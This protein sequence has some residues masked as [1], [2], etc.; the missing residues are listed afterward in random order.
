MADAENMATMER[1]PSTAAGVAGV[2]PDG[3]YG[4]ESVT[5][6]SCKWLY[7][8]ITLD[9]SGRIFPCCAAPRPDMDLVFSQFEPGGTAEVYN[10]EKYQLARLAFAG[11]SLKW[12][13]IAPIASKSTERDQSSSSPPPANMTSCLPHW[14][15][16]AALPMQWALVAHAEL[17]E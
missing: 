12:V 16:S 17:I 4:T 3:H 13:D 6:S 15:I 9:A 14:I 8:S 11:V 2:L 1:N 10:S 5:D 7:R